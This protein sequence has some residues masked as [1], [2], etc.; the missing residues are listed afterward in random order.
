MFGKSDVCIPRDEY[1]LH[2]AFGSS[3]Q[4]KLGPFHE[5]VYVCAVLNDK[6]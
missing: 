2:L 1:H 5:G 3:L 6:L 4:I